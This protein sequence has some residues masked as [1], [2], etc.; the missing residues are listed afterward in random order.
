MFTR[1]ELWRNRLPDGSQRE[2]QG[3]ALPLIPSA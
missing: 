1:A 3:R 2:I